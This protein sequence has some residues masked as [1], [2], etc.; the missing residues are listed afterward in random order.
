M[1]SAPVNLDG[2]ARQRLSFSAGFNERFPL[3]AKLCFK[4]PV[5]SHALCLFILRVYSIE[6]LRKGRCS[7]PY[8]V[9]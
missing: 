1:Y 6:K 9:M 8:V 7:I 4:V 3:I 5:V 2:L